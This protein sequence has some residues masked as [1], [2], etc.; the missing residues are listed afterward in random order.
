MDDRVD[1][2][3]KNKH[4]PASSFASKNASKPTNTNPPNAP[5]TVPNTA[6]HS[7]SGPPLPM[8][9]LIAGFSSLSIEPAPPEIED[10]PAP[11]CPISLIPDELLT[12]ILMEVAIADVASFVRLASVCKRLAY[13]VLTEETIWKRICIGQEV[14]FAAMHYSWNRDLS[15]GP[16]LEDFEGGQVL[17]SADD[18]PE[19]QPTPRLEFK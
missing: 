2:Q 11:P 18:Y 14:G 6:H 13:L 4:F 19:D 10:T 17:G 7:L 16:L 15:G 1:L 9:D 12:H 5:V 3:Y 8:R